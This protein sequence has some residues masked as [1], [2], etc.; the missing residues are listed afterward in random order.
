M[1]QVIAEK[2][3]VY[4][5]TG[6]D[7]LGQPTAVDHIYER[8]QVIPD[9]LD[10]QQAFV[11]TSTGL[12]AEV[13][14]HP[15]DTVRP[16][17]RPEAP[18]VVTDR[19]DETG[20]DQHNTSGKSGTSPGGD[21]PA[22]ANGELEPLPSDAAPKSVWED[23]AAQKLPS[24]LAI[25]RAQAESMTKVRLLTEVKQRYNDAADRDENAPDS[26]TLPPSFGK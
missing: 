22:L 12:A 24:D 21:G 19:V 16:L 18:V 13:G 3:S 17:P 8:G 20:T 2:I 15:D 10:S 7:E 5:F 1:L 6:K 23:Y 4:E 25:G 9:W 26:G 11:L 14:D